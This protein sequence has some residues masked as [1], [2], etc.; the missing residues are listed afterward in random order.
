MLTGLEGETCRHMHA[1]R[2]M[3]NEVITHVSWSSS[4]EV[5]ANRDHWVPLSHPVGTIV[6][7]DKIAG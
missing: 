4:D 5:Y 3:M 6:A 1:L 7:Y 2:V